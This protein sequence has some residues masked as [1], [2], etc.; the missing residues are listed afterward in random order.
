MRN[1]QSMS[2]N[3]KTLPKV[4]AAWVC[5][6]IIAFGLWIIGGLVFNLACGDMK[7]T[8]A[9]ASIPMLMVL[10]VVGAAF[11]LLSGVIYAPIQLCASESKLEGI[12]VTIFTGSLSRAVPGVLIDWFG[13]PRKGGLIIGLVLGA[14]AGILNV[15]WERALSKTR[16]AKT[17]K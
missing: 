12:V 2:W 11:G 5:C 3:W 6:C 8:V 1:Q 9:I 14:T 7:L 15:L 13:L 10:M 16:S 17:S 4:Y